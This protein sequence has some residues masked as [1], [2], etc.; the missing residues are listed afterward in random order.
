MVVHDLSYCEYSSPQARIRSN[1]HEDLP[2]FPEFDSLSSMGLKLPE[3]FA[4]D[5]AAAIRAL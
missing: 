5:F 3:K 1:R 4:F 2:D